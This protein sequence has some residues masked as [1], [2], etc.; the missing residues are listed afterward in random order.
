LYNLKLTKIIFFLE[1]NSLAVTQFEPTDA[2]RS[3]PCF[4]EPAMK[5]E[6]QLTMIRHKNF[7]TTLFNM[8]LIRVLNFTDE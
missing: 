5:A 3:F 4:D 8:P 1:K 6:F 7:S 2:R